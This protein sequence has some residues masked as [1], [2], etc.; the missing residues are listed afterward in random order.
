MKA[1]AKS[2]AKTF[3]GKYFY[4]KKY[5]TREEFLMSIF[6]LFDEDIE[7][8]GKFHKNGRYIARGKS[9]ITGYKNVSSRSW[10]APYLRFAR[11]IFVVN[12]TENTWH[13]GKEVTDKEVVHMLATYG[14]YS[15]QYNG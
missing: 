14:A 5:T 1:I 9:H 3:Y 2:C 4:S 6:T 15:M 13:I 11:K 12:S 10:Y 8:E 7:F